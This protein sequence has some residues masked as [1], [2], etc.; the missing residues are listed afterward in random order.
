MDTLVKKGQTTNGKRD[1]TSETSKHQKTD[2]VTVN[3]TVIKWG[4][5]AAGG[6][7]WNHLV[8][9]RLRKEWVLS[10]EHGA[11]DEDTRQDNVH[12]VVVVNKSMTGN[13][14][15]AIKRQTRNDS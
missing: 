9:V 4:L 12:E 3:G 5:R 8:S 11:T 6:E 2:H 10:S 13:A 14:K 7:E 1:A 15:S